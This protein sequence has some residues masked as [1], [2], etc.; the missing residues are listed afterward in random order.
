M[1]NEGMEYPVTKELW[2]ELDLSN[3]GI[4]ALS[5]EIRYYPHITALY[6][7][8][9][10]LMD[11]ADDAFLELRSLVVLDLSYN[12]LSRIPSSV[13]QLIH[14]ER[15]AIHQNR[16]AELPVELGIQNIINRIINLEF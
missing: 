15:L 10:K 1:M 7:N 3:M 12:L 2:F 4:R 16:V 14:L 9:N 11:L 6:L 5:R 8:N 13:G